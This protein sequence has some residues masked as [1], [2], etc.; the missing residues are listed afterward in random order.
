MSLVHYTF[1]SLIF[2]DYLCK[3]CLYIE[4]EIFYNLHM[5]HVLLFIGYCWTREIPF[6]DSQLLSRCSRSNTGL[7]CYQP[8]DFQ[9]T[10]NL[11]WWIGNIFNNE[12]YCQDGCWEQDWQSR[13]QSVIHCVVFQR[14]EEISAMYTS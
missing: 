10:W 3:E 8:A 4:W 2:L 1:H 7:W 13:L 11:A 14:T 6:V 12:Q 9:E 5:K